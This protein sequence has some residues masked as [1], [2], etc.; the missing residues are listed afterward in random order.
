MTEHKRPRIP[1]GMKPDGPPI[2][3]YGFRPFFLAAAAWAIIAMA[4]WI[5]AIT[6]RSNVGVL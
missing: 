4:L 5:A 2:W 6:K 3:S 1:R